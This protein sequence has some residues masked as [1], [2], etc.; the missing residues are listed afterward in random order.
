M[1]LLWRERLNLH[2]MLY[3]KYHYYNNIMIDS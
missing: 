1:I 3:L 2:N